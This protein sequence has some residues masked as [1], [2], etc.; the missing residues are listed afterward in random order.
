MK[1][2]TVIIS[3]SQLRKIVS[4]SIKR[5]LNEAKI[6]DWGTDDFITNDEYRNYQTIG[7]DAMERNLQKSLRDGCGPEDWCPMCYKQLKNGYTNLYWRNGEGGANYYAHPG[8]GREP[9]KIGNKCL[10]YFEK[11]HNDKYGKKKN[12]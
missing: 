9:I 6:K 4:E 12:G 11:A 7:G 2:N 5:V 8:E 10:T 1:N 3:E